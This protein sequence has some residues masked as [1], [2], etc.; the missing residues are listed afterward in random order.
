[1]PETPSPT[2]LR[3]VL[4]TARQ[5]RGMAYAPYSGFTVGSALLT[6]DGQ[7]HSGCNVEIGSWEEATCAERV[8]ILDAITAGAANERLD[9]IRLIVISTQEARPGVPLHFN[10]PC[11]NCRQLIYDFA[12]AHSCQVVID[13]GKDGQL[14]TL[15]AL[16]PLGYRLGNKLENPVLA[17]C[18]QLEQQALDKPDATGL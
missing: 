8:A 17:N 10:S 18:S 3:R 15:D 2:D 7:I 16:L 14:F 12:D 11:G 6:G 13:D 5:A 9:F 1:M 4:E